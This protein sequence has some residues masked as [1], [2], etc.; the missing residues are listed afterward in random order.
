MDRLIVQ[1]TILAEW[2]SLVNEAQLTSA[3]ELGEEVESYLVFLLMRFT[4]SP[5]VGTSI[6]AI[7]FLE[8]LRLQGKYSREKLQVIGD[9][10]LLFSGLFPELANRRRVKSDYYVDLGQSAYDRLSN[11]H[12]HPVTSEMFSSLCD[13]FIN[14]VEILRTMR[15][16]DGPSNSKQ[17]IERIYNNIK[18]LH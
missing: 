12:I 6:I 16:I 7:E 13:G 4:T 1:P 17:K 15:S 14:V 2:H 10:C 5:E 8:S 9:K 3:L 11:L 18:R